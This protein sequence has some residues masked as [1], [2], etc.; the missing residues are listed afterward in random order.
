MKRLWF[1][2]LTGIVILLAASAMATQNA[3][4]AQL[5]S[6]ACAAAHK[7]HPFLVTLAHVVFIIVMVSFGAIL[8]KTLVDPSNRQR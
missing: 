5:A 7:S 2:F 3:E 6:G 1:L 8:L 4:A